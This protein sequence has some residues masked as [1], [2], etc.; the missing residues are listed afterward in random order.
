MCYP[1]FFIEKRMRELR[2][3][4]I[5]DHLCIGVDQALR[6]VFDNAKTTER[7]YPAQHEKE[8]RLT[9]EQSIY[10][11][12]LMRINHAGEVCAQALYHGQGIISRSSSI[13]NKMRQA[14]LEEGD[15]LAWCRRRLVELGSHT[16]YLNP[17][18]YSGSFMIG[19]TAGLIGDRWSLGFLA[20]TE[21][22]VVQHLERH[23]HLLPLD[24]QKSHLVLNQMQKDESEHRDEALSSGAAILPSAIKKLMNIASNIMVKT[25]R[26]I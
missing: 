16:S 26:W 23:L 18:W 1:L 6:A 10:S 12:A 9:R 25:A 7:A 2:H 22:Q 11:A 17:L 24:D 19:L 3:Y 13:K 15:H 21:H 8:P 4:S 5:V 20:E 14:A